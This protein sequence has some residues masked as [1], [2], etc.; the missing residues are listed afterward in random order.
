M[1]PN[2]P[3]FPTNRTSIRSAPSEARTRTASGHDHLPRDGRHPEPE[4][5]GPL[6]HHRDDRRRHERAVRDGV[7]DLAERRD[8]VEA[9]GDEPVHPVGRPENRQQDR[10]GRLVGAAPNRSQ[11]NTPIPAAVTR[12]TKFG[13]VRIR[14]SP[15]LATAGDPGFVT[16]RDYFGD[17]AY[18]RRSGLFSGDRGQRPPCRAS[19]LLS[20]DAWRVLELAHHLLEATCFART[21]SFSRSLIWRGL[22]EDLPAP[23]QG[24]ARVVLRTQVGELI[25]TSQDRADLHRGRIRAAPGAPDPQQS[26]RCPQRCTGAPLLP[27]DRQAQGAPNSS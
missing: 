4:W 13:T 23:L 9:P 19:S 11:T 14:S 10:C 3:A 1:S 18:F 20:C 12:V 6:D 5:C 22:G 2:V 26:S 24:R 27:S 7:E 8:L 17:S 15:V 25:L 16:G 21:V